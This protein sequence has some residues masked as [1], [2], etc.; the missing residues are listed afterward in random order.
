MAAFNDTELLKF[1]MTAAPSSAAAVV[2]VGALID[3]VEDEEWRAE[4]T[5]A[6][7]VL[8]FAIAKE[9]ATQ[10]IALICPACTAHIEEVG[11]R[12]EAILTKKSEPSS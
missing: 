4:M 1:A 3:E 2:A 12:V 7:Q 9:I 5:E 11:R 10:Y 8:S 6:L